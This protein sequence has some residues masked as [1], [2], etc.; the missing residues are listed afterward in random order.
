MIINK[1][2]LSFSLDIQLC[3]LECERKW[4]VVKLTTFVK[5]FWQQ[6]YL[7]RENWRESLREMAI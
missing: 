1:I 3:H 7:Y 4:L 6:F 5:H 2:N